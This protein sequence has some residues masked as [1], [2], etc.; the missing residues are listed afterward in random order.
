MTY[1]SPGIRRMPGLF[2]TVSRFAHAAVSQGTC[3]NLWQAGGGNS[4]KSRE[5]MSR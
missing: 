5:R 2:K 3:D 1:S 4:A